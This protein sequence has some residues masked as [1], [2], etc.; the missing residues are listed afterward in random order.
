MT[1]SND[2]TSSAGDIVLGAA[3]AG[4][5]AIN[6]GSIIAPGHTVSVSA[7]TF[8][9]PT[10]GPNPGTIVADT[11]EFGPGT[12]G[13]TVTL[14][15]I[16]LTTGRI[17]ASNIRVGEV[18][19]AVT[20]GG[21][22]I[23]GFDNGG[24]PLEVDATGPVT[25]TGTLTNVSILTGTA[26]SF[27]LTNHGNT[28]AQLGGGTL[29]GGTLSTSSGGSIT[30]VDAGRVTLA[31]LV[32]AGNGGTV[33][34][35]TVGAFS[36]TQGATASDDRGRV[37][38]CAR[39]R[40]CV[41]LQGTLNAISAITG[42]IATALTLVDNQAL[43]LGG[44]VSVGTAGT[45]DISHHRGGWFQSDSR[46]VRATLTAGT[47]TSTN[48]ISG[49]ISL[50][51]IANAIG[52]VAG[53][54]AGGMTVV[55]NQALT[56]AGLV[57]AGSSGTVDLSTMPGGFDVAQA[58]SGTLI[59]GV[60]SST[61][62][63]SGK[64]NLQG[65]F[66]AIGTISGLTADGLLVM[67]GQP[68][69][70]A[71]VVSVGASGTADLSTSMG[72]GFSVTQGSSGALTAGLLISDS[73]ISGGAILR[74][75]GNQIG[76]ISGLTAGGLTVVDNHALTLVG[77]VNVG[78]T[79]TVDLSTTPGG[80]F[81]VI[82]GAGGTLTAGTLTSAI[83]ISG[84]L[85]LRGI[86]NAIGT[87]SGVSAGG[88]SLVNNHML[89]LA[90]LV[91]AGAS[92]TVDL[93]TTAG[94]GFDVVQ[95]AGGSLI[96]GALTSAGGISGNAILRGTGNQVGTITGLTASNLTV[97]DSRTLT[98]AGVGQRRC[99]RHTRRQHI[100]GSECSPGGVRDSHRRRAD[101][102]ERDRRNRR[103]ARYIGNQIGTLAGFASTGSLAVVNGTAMTVA[104]AVG[105][106]AGNVFLSTG[107]STLTF[108]SDGSIGA[109]PGG[110]IGL[111]AES[112]DQ[113]GHHRRD[114]RGEQ[115]RRGHVRACPT[116]RRSRHLGRVRGAGPDQHDRHHRG[117]TGDRRRDASRRQ[118]SHDFR[119]C[120]YRRGYV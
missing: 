23:A 66:N 93:T 50:H 42:L 108:A 65:A 95:G 67:D 80:G 63:I 85:A 7:A 88:L 55:D 94:A 101:Q 98:L 35:S 116:H 37:D 9:I 112:S 41:N 14:G 25:Q 22:I 30:I 54:T 113:P 27:A 119:Q 44:A 24:L 13:G 17:G 90:G 64:L 109:V 106:T 47:L 120:D 83:G 75:T 118:R 73:G 8:T 15:G 2:I 84:D 115:R 56:L 28:I 78:S 12:V 103:P 111:S 60:L 81:D 3:G 92:G 76:A 89:T 36:V 52:T 59:G 40:R 5:L 51:G 107:T 100:G 57:S 18:N 34:L 87:V 21:V 104:G 6:A 26:G 10:S 96:A 16:G 32:S 48:G 77:A 110:R 4:G 79:G 20:A 71:G 86:E 69:V 58:S 11:F 74:G 31:G 45:V 29:A 105:A 117:R 68:L 91:S 99:V 72:A 102:C 43:I 70:L 97:F 1:L 33:D 53:V 114:G 82:Q 39:H 38:Q 62:G 19:G 49:T 46:R 61:S